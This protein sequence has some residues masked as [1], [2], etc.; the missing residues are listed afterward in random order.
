MKICYFALFAATSAR[1][2]D[3]ERNDDRRYDDLKQMAEKVWEEHSPDTPFDERKFWGYGCH[4][5]FPNDR[6]MSSMGF[7]KPK[8]GIDRACHA[9][10]LCQKCVREE[11]GEMCIGKR[12]L[13]KIVVFFVLNF[14]FPI[15]NFPFPISDFRFPVSN[16][17]FPI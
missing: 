12:F 3:D 17:R 6:P 15:L 1:P 9:W 14:P 16:I 8:D 13:K 10:K 4:C 11:H 5:I 2:S 7:G